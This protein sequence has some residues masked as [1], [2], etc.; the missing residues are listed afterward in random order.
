MVKRGSDI[1]SADSFCQSARAGEEG[2]PN[3][4]RYYRGLESKDF[5]SMIHFRCRT[6][7]HRI[8]DPLR[9]GDVTARYELKDGLW[10]IEELVRLR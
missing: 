1:K 6:L 8:A 9:K 4:C 5:A 7:S 3:G 2:D 10:D